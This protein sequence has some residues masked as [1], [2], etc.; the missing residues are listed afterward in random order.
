MKKQSETK[1]NKTFTE[2]IFNAEGKDYN[3]PHR[4]DWTTVFEKV[5]I[6]SMIF[7]VLY[8]GLHLFAFVVYQL[9]N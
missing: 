6:F 5:A 4:T 3:T 1:P 9:A 7:A 2:N 8:F